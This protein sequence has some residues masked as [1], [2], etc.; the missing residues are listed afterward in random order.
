M[1]AGLVVLGVA[2]VAL[3]VVVGFVKL[4]NKSG[5]Q[6]LYFDEIQSIT[7]S[8]DGCVQLQSAKPSCMVCRSS[9]VWIN[10]ASVPACLPM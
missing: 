5:F 4:R 8:S 7:S 6:A 9:I 10:H 1:Q 2:V 3:L